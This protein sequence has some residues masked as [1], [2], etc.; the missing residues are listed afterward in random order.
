MRLVYSEGDI[1]FFRNA[2]SL[3]D[4]TIELDWQSFKS[5]KKRWRTD[6][7]LVKATVLV[8]FDRPFVLMLFNSFNMEQLHSLLIVN[9]PYVGNS[10]EEEKT[11]VRW[12]FW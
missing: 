3:S 6:A 5:E 11:H 10:A 2:Q 1:H 12:L 7:H 9:D 8:M 4:K